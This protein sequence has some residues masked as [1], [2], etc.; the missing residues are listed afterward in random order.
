[1]K[2]VNIPIYMGETKAKK[3]LKAVGGTDS[4]AVAVV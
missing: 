3:V 4:F 2:N 1:M